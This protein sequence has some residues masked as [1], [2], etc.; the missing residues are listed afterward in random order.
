MQHCTQHFQV[1][2]QGYET[3]KRARDMS[4]ILSKPVKTCKLGSS[5]VAGLGVKAVVSP[6]TPVTRITS[7]S[8]QNLRPISSSL[9]PEM[10]AAF[11]G[12]PLR[13]QGIQLL[14]HGTKRD[15]RAEL[16]L[17]VEMD[18]GQKYSDAY[19]CGTCS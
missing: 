13:R 19:R 2:M 3:P 6:S 8:E 1:K 18:V 15:G 5:S 9:T 12:V 4:G 16:E 7:I 14:R 10:L 11:A 17:G